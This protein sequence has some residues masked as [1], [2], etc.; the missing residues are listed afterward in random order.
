M[1][2]PRP[3]VFLISDA[4]LGSGPDSDQRCARLVSL[5][6]GFREHASH[7]YILGDLFDFWFEYRHAV[8]KG[9]F[10]ILR[11]LADLVDAGVQV[12][13][14]GGNH[15]FWCGSYLEREVGLE[16][17]QHPIR[18]EHQG[19]RLLLAHGDGIGPGDLGYRLLKRILR[20]PLAIAGYRMLHPDLGIPLAHRVS[21]T[22]RRHT[23]G[24]T[25]YLR[26]MS[27]YLVAPAF[28]E[29]HDAVIVGHVHDPQHLRDDRNREFL[30]VGDWLE[31]FTYVRL[32]E[33]RFT[34]E[35]FR[36]TEAPTVLPATP[37]P[38][39]LEPDS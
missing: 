33:G 35:Q 38:D 7:L 19:R 17:H 26:Q 16:V 37:W 21:G 4:H 3:S 5:L 20:H 6:D 23:K 28:A 22:S 32:E 18:V 11:A 12:V 13:Y 10:R 34:L 31:F 8:P 30:I 39:G 24:R 25:F 1:N 15:D 2:I 14:L 36:D 27:R 9:H 29:G